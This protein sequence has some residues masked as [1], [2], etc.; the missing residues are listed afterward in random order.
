MRGSCSFGARLRQGASLC[1]A[2]VAPVRLA[3]FQERADP[4][5]RVGEL[6]GRSHDLE[7]VGVRLRLIE[8]DLRIERLLTDPLL[9]AEPRV[10]RSRRSRTASSS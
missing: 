7:G 3:L 10:T 4:F 6:A 8:I 1:L 9:S 2:A 5:L